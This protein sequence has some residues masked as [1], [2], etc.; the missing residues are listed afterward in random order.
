ME[1]RVVERYTREVE[2]EAFRRYE[3]D[4]D[5][6]DA[7]LDRGILYVRLPR[8]ESDRPRKIEIRHRIPS[9]KEVVR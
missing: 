7:N 2:R 9:G 6:I 3:I 4:A 8:A 1:P 5:R